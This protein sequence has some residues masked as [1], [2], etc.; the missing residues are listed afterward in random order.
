MGRQRRAAL[1][2]L[3][4]AKKAAGGLR[5]FVFFKAARDGDPPVYVGYVNRGRRKVTLEEI[6]AA[7]RELLEAWVLDRASRPKHPRTSPKATGRVS[8]TLEVR[9]VVAARQPAVKQTRLVKCSCGIRTEIDAAEG[10]TRTCPR[11]F[12]QLS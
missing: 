4:E 9:A 7:T 11:C 5:T 10:A 3:I 6:E 8:R 1:R 12:K 2:K